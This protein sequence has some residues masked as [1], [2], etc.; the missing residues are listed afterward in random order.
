MVSLATLQ[1]G[2]RGTV[3]VLQTDDNAI[4][5]KLF[6]LG[7]SPGASLVLEQ[8]HPSF[9]IRVG[10]TRAALDQGIAQTIYLHCH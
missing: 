8:R 1:R 6:A 4:A 5:N 9:I 3:A 2:D 10:R 7:I